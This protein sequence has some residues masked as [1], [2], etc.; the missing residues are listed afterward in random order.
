MKW[1]VDH[2]L[3]GEGEGKDGAEWEKIVEDDSRWFR[4]PEGLSYPIA[5]ENMRYQIHLYRRL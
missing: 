1:L 4:L 2:V 3:L 5:L